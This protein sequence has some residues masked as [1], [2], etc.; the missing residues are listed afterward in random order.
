MIAVEAEAYRHVFNDVRPHE[1]LGM[2][3]PAERYLG[4]ADRTIPT[5]SI[6]TQFEPENLPRFMTRDTSAA[7]R[8]LPHS[9]DEWREVQAATGRFTDRA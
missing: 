1:S 4:H 7:A 9:S 8:A 6:P 2:A 5:A 3:R